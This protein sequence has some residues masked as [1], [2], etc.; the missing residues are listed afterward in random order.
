MKRPKKKVAIIGAGISG[1]YLAW[2]ISKK[3]NVTVF[4]K[5]NY[6]GG[7][8]NTINVN[9]KKKIVPVDTGFIV[10][11]KRNYPNLLQFFKMLNIK[12]KKS[13]M[14]FSLYLN[15]DNFYYS[16]NFSGI[17]AQKKN[18]ISKNFW[19]MLF[20][21]IT[22]YLRVP[23]KIKKIKNSITLE[24]Y[25][26]KEGYSKYFKDRHIYPMASAIWSTKRGV[27]NK[28]PLK[29]FINFFNNH[30]LFKFFNRPSWYTVSGGSQNYI[31][32]VLKKT[33]AKFIKNVKVIKIKKNNNKVE[34]FTNK[35]KAYF[36]YAVCATHADETSEILKEIDYKT[37]VLLEKFKY[38]KNKTYLH[39]DERL[40]PKNKKVWSSWNYVSF[41][42]KG[43]ENNCFSYWMNK[44]QNIDKK[45][46]FFLS[47]NPPFKPN[48][49]YYKT[50]YT[51]P[52]FTKKSLEITK[53]LEKVQGKNK[54]W[55]CGSYFYN[56]FHEDAVNSSIKIAKLLN[57]EIS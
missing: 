1:L 40:M 50:T 44:L 35:S 48:N 17:F 20:E 47:L 37:S 27:I 11:N 28:M 56:G 29:S 30:G 12:I 8:S 45:Y 34:V 21:I 23:L 41:Y 53:K 57:N 24:E 16:G 6:F 52:I 49:I 25:L 5:N 3:F 54:I 19:I 39:S 10:F 51:H 7:H 46:P 18:L 33:S 31:K 32:E 26:N 15:K 55:F 22:F 14:S 36:D 13:D 43:K 9:L 2:K 4:E 42:K 38:S